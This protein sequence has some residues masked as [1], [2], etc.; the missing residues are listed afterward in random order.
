M[1]KEARVGTV[2]QN[3]LARNSPLCSALAG[4]RIEELFAIGHRVSV[5]EGGYL[6]HE[7]DPSTYVYNISSGVSTLE[8]LASDGRRQIMAF[9]Y[10]GDFVGITSGA[11]YS[12]S[13]RALTPLTACR[14][15]VRDLEGLY[16]KY[17]AL[18][19]RIH[20]IASRVLAATMDQLFVLG[21]KNAVEKI[22]YFLLF[23]DMKQEKFDGHT[24]SF[25]LPMSRVDIADYLGITVET[26]S[27]TI[28]TLKRLGLIEVSQSWMVNLK[29]KERLRDIAEHYGPVR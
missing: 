20:E 9:V 22:A 14:W 17:P 4:D 2:C 19:Q 3:C 6:L 28:S 7:E 1:L 26:V 16:K 11:F 13:G 27:R 18:E 10:P 12:V 8:R 23:I 5:E 24:D 29:D 15:H 21:R 25:A